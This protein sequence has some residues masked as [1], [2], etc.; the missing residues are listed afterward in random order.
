M[1]TNSMWGQPPRL[2]TDASGNTVLSGAASRNILLG[3]DVQRRRGGIAVD[4]SAGLGTLS[5]PTG[6]VDSAIA[7]DT[8]VTYRGNPTV[9]CTFSTVSADTFVGRYTLTNPVSFKSFKNITIPIKITASDAVGTVATAANPFGVWLKTASGK[10]IRFRLVADGVGPDNWALMSWVR[11]ETNSVLSFAGGATWDT[12]DSETITEIDLVHSA[13]TGIVSNAYPIWIGPVL[14]DSLSTSVV[15]IRMDGQYSSQYSLAWPVLQA[16]G[17]T[18]SLMA[19][20]SNL[21]TAGYMTTAQVDAMY[22]GGCEVGM[23]TFDGTKT[24]GYANETDW[25]S[26]A[27]ITDDIVAGYAAQLAQ[28]WYRGVGT[29]AEAFN[30]AYFSG[31]TTLA[32]QRLLKQALSSA[33]VDCLCRLETSYKMKNTLGQSAVRP[34]LLRSNVSLGSTTVAADVVAQINQVK[35]TGEWLIIT[36]HEVVADSATPTGNQIK[37]SDFTTICEAI[38]ANVEAGGQYCLPIGEAYARTYS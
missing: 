35:D 14:I 30:G 3:N 11:G 17:L 26:A 24:N 19:I 6:G 22:D 27:V 38:A 20:H 13:A 34:L 28:G 29:L 31:A 21:D 2:T 23:H 33:G 16:N 9:K 10:Q 8:G 1:G 15:S 32:R 7:L 4:W 37:V 12:L 5:K 25:P 36:A 18:A